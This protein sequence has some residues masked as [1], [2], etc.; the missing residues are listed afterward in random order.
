M[1]VKILWLH[2]VCH[3]LGNPYDGWLIDNVYVDG[4]LISDGTDAAVFKD[5]TEVV[6]I[7]NDFTVTFV[8]I[9]GKGNST[10]YKVANMKLDNVTESG[11][12][13]LNKILKWSDKAVMLVTYDAAEGT[14]FYADYTYGFAFTNKGPKK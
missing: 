14:T 5:I 1:R 4:T 13:E 10:Q 8:G 11:L 2:S 9:K 3:G 6:P 12:F 7:N